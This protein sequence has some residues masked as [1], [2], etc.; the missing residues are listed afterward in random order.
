MTNFWLLDFNY[1]QCNKAQWKSPRAFLKLLGTITRCLLFLFSHLFI[2]S[3]FGFNKFPLRTV[4][5]NLFIILYKTFKILLKCNSFQNPSETS[6]G[7]GSSPD[8][9]HCCSPVGFL[10][11][12]RASFLENRFWTKMIL[13]RIYN[14]FFLIKY[15]FEN[16]KVSFI[17]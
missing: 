7:G 15:P 3:F 2:Y 6:P 1:C 16:F 8:V 9:L 11:I 13:Y 12:F 17:L 10:Y 4:N 5:K 14:L